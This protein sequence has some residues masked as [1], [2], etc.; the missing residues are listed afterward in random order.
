MIEPTEQ[1]FSDPGSLAA[2][3]ALEVA[4]R[5]RDGISARGQALLAVS[6]GTTPEK[7]LLLLGRQAL[8]WSR[9]TVTL[10]DER[11]VAP[12]NSRSNEQL[13]R[14]TLLSGAAAAA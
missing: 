12:D 6:G 4:T 7:F 9:I 10:T 8:D 3:L 2:A 11:W 13:L 14:R 1:R 5:L